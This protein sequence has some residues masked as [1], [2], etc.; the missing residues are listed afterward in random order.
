MEDN[1]R[2]NVVDLA[3]IYLDRIL[4]DLEEFEFKSYEFTNYIYKQL[5]N[6]DII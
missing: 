3:V 4:D 5:F 1:Y 6:I 2:N